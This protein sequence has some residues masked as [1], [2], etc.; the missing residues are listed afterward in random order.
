MD[1]TEASGV[2]ARDGERTDGR[3]RALRRAL[4]GGGLAL[5]VA[6]A[7]GVPA[8]TGP[9][10]ATPSS[11]GPAFSLMAVPTSAGPD[12]PFT[13]RLEVTG[14]VPLSKLSLGITVYTPLA[15]RSE[16]DETL[17]G[18]PVGSIVWSGAVAVSA[19][20]SDP[21]D[22]QTG[23][24]LTLPV[25][26]G[27]VAGAGSGPS[28]AVLHCQLGSCGGVYPTRL[29]LAD[30]AT[31]A[32][33]SRLLTY[34]VYADPPP[35]TEPL[36]LAVVVPLV[37]PPGP[38][39]AA[40]ALDTSSV[41]ALAGL[42]GALS[43]PRASVPLTLAPDPST[44][45]ALAADHEARAQ[46][47]LRSLASLSDDAG[48][49]TLCGPFVPVNAS[50]LGMSGLGAELVAQVRR[51]AQALTAAGIRTDDCST[52]NVWVTASALDPTA[53]AALAALGYG[54]LTVPD[55]AVAGPTLSTTPTRRFTM[56][57]SGLT[58]NAIL[59]DPGLS[60][61]LQPSSP[62]D[63][64]LSADQ[65]VAE[66]SL[67]YYE[68]PNT[69]TPRGVVAVPPANW[70]AEPSFLTDVLAGL[71]GD[72]VVEPVTLATMFSQVPVGG[73]VGQVTQPATRRPAPI[74]GSPGLPVHA[75]RTARSRWTAFAG[76]VAGSGAGSAVAT[77]LDDML[78]EAESAQLKTARQEAG[79]RAFDHA[80]DR[81]L[82]LLSI[83]SRNVR[84]TASTG[85]VPITV[86]KD[87]PYPVSAVLT[88]TSDKLTFPSD[89]TQAA[90]STCGPPVVHASP[91][92][93]SVSAQCVLKHTTNVV[94]IDMRSR[95]SGHFRTSVTLTS[96][97][98]D[99]VLATGQLTVS[100][101]S[102]SAVA[103]A[104]SAVAAA[105]L[106]GW[107]GRTMW[108][109][110]RRRRGAHRRGAGSEPGAQP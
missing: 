59:S 99:L 89:G 37:V 73:V 47:V 29:E 17:G 13:A 109:T 69:P 52:D 28:T 97:R 15:D 100:S 66:A 18:N 25:T 107:W 31:G 49:Q 83:A 44:I 7:V 92:R 23:V 68:A 30:T 82:G 81:Q 46:Q 94:Y 26:A 58:G 35:D 98:G 20:P 19:L 103:I 75:I 84:L 36:R 8:P 21:A 105:V 63:D 106:L 27:G 72:P 57:G 80:L 104:L 61:R 86:I 5:V 93:S 4:V 1:R 78:L 64:A 79:V 48:R 10:G 76:V 53:V 24:D 91:N 108:R 85:D 3:H 16:F 43:G 102:T 55:T 77:S 71:Q 54:D 62:T 6:C 12:Q 74:S 88:V 32:V 65:L 101:M 11:G 87:A 60:T 2:P 96:P 67:I 110:R 50:L 40:P 39:G 42:A 45:A 9:A 38:A 33:T 56:G 51:G 90:N 34:L 70:H 22:P 14:D 41:E 95:V